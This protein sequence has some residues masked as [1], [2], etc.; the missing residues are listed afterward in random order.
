M[1]FLFDVMS[2]LIYDPFFVDVPRAFQT[3]LSTFLKNKDR[4]AWIDF[5]SNRIDEQGFAQRFSPDPTDALRM[6]EAIFA[7]YRWLDG[8][9]KLLQQ[10]RAQGHSISTLS[11][12]PCWY[13]ELRARM[14]L[15]S[16]VDHHFVSYQIEA[17]KPDVQIYAHVLRTLE[18]DADQAVFIDDRAENVHAAQSLGITS[19]CFEDAQKLQQQFF[20]KGYITCQI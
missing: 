13:E 5:E 15:D 8:M 18:I 4:F 14:E 20:Q 12:Y 7:N 17:R 10:L 11:N 19:F 16:F 6:R 2:T 1:Y 9:K 3:S